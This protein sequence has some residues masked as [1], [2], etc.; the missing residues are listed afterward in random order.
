VKG[1]KMPELVILFCIFCA[2]PDVG[3]F[4]AAFAFRKNL[5]IAK[6]IS[7]SG[8]L[9]KIKEAG[10]T[11]ETMPLIG[12][13]EKRLKRR[14]SVIVVPV[15]MLILFSAFSCLMIISGFQNN[16]DVSSTIVKCLF[17]LGILM[18]IASVVVAYRMLKQN[19]NC[20]DYTKRRGVCLELEARKV[21]YGRRSPRIYYATVSYLS[22]DGTPV[23]FEVAVT[24]E[25][26]YAMRYEK[27]WF[28]VVQSNNRN[29]N[30]IPENSLYEMVRE[31]RENGIS[32]H[33]TWKG[34]YSGFYDK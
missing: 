29:V 30:V 5:R 2:L 31:D 33:M 12:E 16:P 6:V 8:Y 32:R 15:M 7:T 4:I 10:L 22:D 21:G 19:N 25:L 26:Y 13:D 17:E 14:N 27:G 1:L 24:D 23:V 18:G 28:V 11:N 3:L 9:Y 34:I 20:T